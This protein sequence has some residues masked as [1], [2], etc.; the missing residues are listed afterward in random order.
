MLRFLYYPD[1][2][3]LLYHRGHKEKEQE[4]VLHKPYGM[5]LPS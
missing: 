5:L 4:N 1:D 2:D 3:I